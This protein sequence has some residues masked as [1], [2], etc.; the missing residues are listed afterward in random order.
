MHFDMCESPPAFSRATTAEVAQRVEQLC[1]QCRCLRVPA[2]LVNEA[3]HHN[4]AV[5][6]LEELQRRALQGD[7]F[8]REKGTYLGRQYELAESLSTLLAEVEKSLS[9]NRWGRWLVQTI[10]LVVRR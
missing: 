3:C 1:A 7:T 10:R 6:S 5:E 8:A 2:W 4:L 9:V